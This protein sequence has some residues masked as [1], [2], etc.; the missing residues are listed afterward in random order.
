MLTPEVQ[1]YLTG[2]LKPIYPTADSLAEAH[3]R[4]NEALPGVS[5]SELM[6]LLHLHQNTIITLILKEVNNV[7]T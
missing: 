1:Q 3:Q 7:R 6:P 2:L 4:I 5:R